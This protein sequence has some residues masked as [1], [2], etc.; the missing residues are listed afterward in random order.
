ME[1]ETVPDFFLV[2]SGNNFLGILNDIKRRPEDAA[3][4]LKISIDE[5]NL[6]ISGQKNISTELIERAIKI[7]PVNERDFYIISDDCPTGVKIMS[8]EESKKS[9]RIMERAGKPYYEYRDTAM[10]SVAP[11]RPEWI[12][13]LCY[14]NDNDAENPIIQWNNGH[15]LHQFTYF[16]GEVNFYYIDDDI[17]DGQ[18]YC[19]QI[20]LI[21]DD[22]NEILESMEQCIDLGLDL[23]QI[24]GDI[25]DDGIVNILDIV[26]LINIVLNGFE[27][28]DADL[29]EDGIINIL[30]VI[31]MINILVGGLP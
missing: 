11:F 29:N 7:W 4:E 8:T 24:L 28:P 25:N 6:I 27:N 30:D 18:F 17:L 21:D 15:F 3:Q 31:V 22:G 20:M 12:M 1:K 26:T 10:S 13:E 14:V 9:S 19:Y 23:S 16:I 5:I 2:R